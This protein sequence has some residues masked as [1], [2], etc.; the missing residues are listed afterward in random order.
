MADKKEKLKNLKKE[1]EELKKQ[2][3][4]YLAGWQRSQADLSN[5]KKE[6]IARIGELLK[7]S[8]EELILKIFPILD[9]FETAEKAVSKDLK[10]NEHFK[11]VLQIKAQL[12][13]LLKS[14]GLEEIKT[15][16]EKFN[17]N[18]QEVV[19]EVEIKEKESGTITEEIQKGYILHGKVL[20]P[21]K[22]KVVK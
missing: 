12:K 13:S 6:E 22:V 18:F 5:Y 3:E 4:E 1:L 17:P 11:G 19:K 15:V 16:G 2:K 21:A 8:T 14:L 7:Y 10:D 20:R 9:N